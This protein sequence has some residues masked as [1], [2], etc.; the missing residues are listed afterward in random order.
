[1]TLEQLVDLIRELR[2][3]EPSP[4]GLW[5]VDRPAL[6]YWLL[7]TA[8]DEINHLAFPYRFYGIPIHQFSPQHATEEELDARPGFCRLPGVWVE[9]SDGNHVRLVDE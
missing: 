3:D 4:V 7:G 9:M 2:L 8:G 6:F 5:F 1:M